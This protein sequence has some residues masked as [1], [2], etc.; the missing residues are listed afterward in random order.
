ATKTCFHRGATAP[1][2]IINVLLNQ[3]IDR[4]V[5]IKRVLRLLERFDVR[6]GNLLFV[7]SQSQLAEW[8]ERRR[9]KALLSETNLH[10]LW[11]LNFRY[12]GC[13]TFRIGSSLCHDG[14]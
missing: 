9:I 1:L 4:E 14:G 5:E 2:V 12:F 6:L 10:R 13:F 11:L 7:L 3:R 8:I